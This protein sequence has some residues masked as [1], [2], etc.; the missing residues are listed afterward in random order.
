MFNLQI[1]G[2]G[3]I[4]PGE[5][6]GPGKKAMI[7]VGVGVG[8]GVEVGGGSLMGVGVGSMAQEARLTVGGD[9]TVKAW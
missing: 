9:F 7:G 1:M 4:F 3:I 2:K 8:I 6:K 5:L